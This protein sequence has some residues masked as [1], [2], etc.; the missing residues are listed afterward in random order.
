MRQKIGLVFIT[1]FWVQ[2]PTLQYYICNHHY[3]QRRHFFIKYKHMNL[4][5]NKF[6]QKNKPN[7]RN[8]RLE[9]SHFWIIVVNTF[10]I[11][12]V[13]VCMD[14]RFQVVI[15]HCRIFFHV[16][17]PLVQS[18]K[19]T[20]RNFSDKKCSAWSY[21]GIR[22]LILPARFVFDACHCG[23]RVR[24]CVSE[25]YES[26]NDHVG[27]VNINRQFSSAVVRVKTVD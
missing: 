18:W 1:K 7:Y 20:F 2:E 17:N 21:S 10:G 5:V 11:T 14:F 4:F 6:T 23:K 19:L 9:C 26:S 22:L 24:G 25:Y 8:H 27:N 12:F 3:Y 16:F 15:L 13:K